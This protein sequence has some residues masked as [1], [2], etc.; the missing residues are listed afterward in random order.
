MRNIK[1]ISTFHTK[2]YGANKSYI[3]AIEKRTYSG[4]ADA[5]RKSDIFT[6]TYGLTEYLQFR[7][8]THIAA[9]HA[10]TAC[11]MRDAFQS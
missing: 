10:G 11:N 8:S 2:V 9:N 7:G 4:L 1:Y 3:Q 6:I 5:L